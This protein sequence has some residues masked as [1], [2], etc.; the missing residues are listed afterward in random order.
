[1]LLMVEI[2]CNTIWGPLASKCQYCNPLAGFAVITYTSLFDFTIMLVERWNLF[3]RGLGAL[4]FRSN[5]LTQINPLIKQ[6]R[7]SSI[8]KPQVLLLLKLQSM[9]FAFL[10][11]I[12]IP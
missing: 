10:D 4:A 5:P 12:S 8:D 2:V 7:I 6:V 1:M 3:A 9:Q 11:A